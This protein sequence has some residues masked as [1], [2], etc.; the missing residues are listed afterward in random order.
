MSAQWSE[1]T[2]ADIFLIRSISAGIDWP[3]FAF[4]RLRVRR[5]EPEPEVLAVRLVGAW[6]DITF[7]QG[8]VD[9]LQNLDNVVAGPSPKRGK[10]ILID[11]MFVAIP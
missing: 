7:H 11:F 3:A 1:I 6:V 8:W 5:L 4:I 10:F 2:Q 9:R